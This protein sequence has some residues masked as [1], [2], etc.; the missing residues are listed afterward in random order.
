MHK[1]YLRRFGVEIECGMPNGLDDAA[2]VFGFPSDEYGYPEYENGDGWTLHDDGS[3]VEL[4]TPILKGETGHEKIKWAMKRLKD[5]G[6]FV[7][8]YDGLHVHHDA[9]EFVENPSL[10][11]PLVESW[12]NN[13]DAIREFVSPRRHDRMA[14]PGWN[15]MQWDALLK[16]IEGG[17]QLYLNRSDLNLL[18]L[19]EHGSIEIRLLEGTLDAEV[20][21][22]WI[23][24]G[25]RLIHDVVQNAKPITKVTT[26]EDLLGKI[27]LTAE[28]RTI[29]LAKK[30]ANHYTDGAAFRDDYY[31]GDD[32]YYDDG[33]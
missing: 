32:D 14:C 16:W 19:R 9:P 11:V 25:Q 23:Q 8:D 6:A 27:K 2:A 24:F 4:G 13:Q 21:I 15:E 7:T 26:G 29:L 31:G 5:N 10:C 33:Y 1:A 3:G 28:A 12:M 20:V 17:E 30:A 18:S 22:A